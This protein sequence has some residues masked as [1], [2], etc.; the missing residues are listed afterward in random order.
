MA[1]STTKGASETAQATAS[2]ADIASAQQSSEA[3]AK[4]MRAGFRAFKQAHSGVEVN[5]SHLNIVLAHFLSILIQ[6]ASNA[7]SAVYLIAEIC[8]TAVHECAQGVLQRRADT[9][10]DW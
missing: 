6:Q 10:L 8:T 3:L 1:F 5:L 7:K 2:I 4:S 9:T